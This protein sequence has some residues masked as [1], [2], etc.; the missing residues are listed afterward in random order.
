MWCRKRLSYHTKRKDRTKSWASSLSRVKVVNCRKSRKLKSKIC[1]PNWTTTQT[2]IHII[3]V[4]QLN[5]FVF[6][7]IPKA[8]H[9][10]MSYNTQ[11]GIE[12][13]VNKTCWFTTEVLD[14]KCPNK[15]ILQ[16]CIIQS[17]Y[18][19]SLLYSIHNVSPIVTNT[20]RAKSCL[21]VE[22]IHM[23][24]NTYIHSVSHYV[25]TDI[26]LQLLKLQHI[27]KISMLFQPSLGRESC[28]FFTVRFI[29]C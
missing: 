25:G 22:Y 1:E 19:K 21:G 26:F 2:Y 9:P 15:D 20:K 17:G 14:F 8:I 5:D 23:Y 4:I 7:N 28:S 24:R 3:Y 29:L 11:Y 16:H 13:H 27:S 18:K 10:N 6:L 12:S